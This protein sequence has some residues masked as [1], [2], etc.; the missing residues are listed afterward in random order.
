MDLGAGSQSPVPATKSCDPR[1][2]TAR[3]P[4]SDGQAEVKSELSVLDAKPLKPLVETRE[5]AAAVEQTML[6]AGPRRMRF[7][8]YI[9]A[10]RVARLA[11]GRTRL[12]GAPVRHEDRD[13]VIVRVDSFLHR[14]ILQAGRGYSEAPPAIQ[15]RSPCD[16][17]SPRLRQG[18]PGKIAGPS[19]RTLAS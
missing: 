18:C 13:F 2:A 17:P 10:Q 16:T 12:V 1:M 6:P 3:N 4:D 11:V 9:Q 15:S 7:R 19:F 8:I 14:T 5:L